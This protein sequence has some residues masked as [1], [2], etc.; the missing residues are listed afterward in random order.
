[1]GIV[2]TGRV[3][4]NAAPQHGGRCFGMAGRGGSRTGQGAGG[5]RERRSQIARGPAQRYV[6]GA[7]RDE[8]GGALAE[9]HLHVGHV[10]RV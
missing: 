10:G 2:W 3:E 7:L 8:P 4:Q 5:S 1:M 6:L 9:L